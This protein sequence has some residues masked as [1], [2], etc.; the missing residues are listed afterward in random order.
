MDCA[1][2]E[3]ARGLSQV[4]NHDSGFRKLDVDP[5]RWQSVMQTLSTVRD[6]L[7]LELFLLVKTSLG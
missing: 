3:P 2:R 5:F 1:S 7:Y 4:Y 6:C